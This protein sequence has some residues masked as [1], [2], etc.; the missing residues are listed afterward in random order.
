MNNTSFNN[1]L[2]CET[3]KT[4]R[5][6]RTKIVN[7][8]ATVDQKSQVVG[9]TVLMDAKLTN[10]DIIRAGSKAYIKEK[11]LRDS[12]IFKES[13]ECDTLS[14]RFLPVDLSLVEFIV[15]PPSGEVA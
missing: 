14:E 9:L 6:I 13:F 11:A 8:M 2:I 5:T 4:D 15:P 12:P 1:K 7:G 10:G 3:Y